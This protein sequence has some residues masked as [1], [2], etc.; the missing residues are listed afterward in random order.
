MIIIFLICRHIDSL[1]RN[2]RVLR[3][4]LV[5]LTVRRL[6][7]SI[8]VNPR[9]GSQRVDQTDVRSLRRLNG[10]HS[11][12]VGIVYVTHLESG[13]VSGKTAGAKSRETSLMCQF[14]KRVVL[15]HKLRQLGRTEKFLYRSLHRFDIDQYLRRYLLRV[16]SRHSLA[17]HSFQTG[18]TDTVLVL[19]KLAHRTDTSVAQMVDIVVV[20]DTVLQMNVIVNGSKDIFLRNMLWNQLMYILADRLGQLSGIAAVLVQNLL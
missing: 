14:A 5:D 3:I 17:N 19:Q 8:L 7:K 16:M 2:A 10:A 1:V 20:S 4:A 6:H 12:V 9:I 11:A 15:I 13:T 18:K